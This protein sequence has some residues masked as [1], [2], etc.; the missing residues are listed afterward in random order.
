MKPSHGAWA[1]AV[2]GEGGGLGLAGPGWVGGC[3][4]REPGLAP[5]ARAGATTASSVGGG[6][7]KDLAVSPRMFAIMPNNRTRNPKIRG[8]RGTRKS[9]LRLK[10]G[11]DLRPVGR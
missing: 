10:V 7:R 11:P 8:K 9:M 2:E 6:D 1:V 4:Q 3:A 5:L